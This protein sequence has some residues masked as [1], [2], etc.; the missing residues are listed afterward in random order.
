M[1]LVKDANT[2]SRLKTGPVTAISGSMHAVLLQIGLPPLGFA[3][4][5]GVPEC[6]PAI[7]M[8]GRG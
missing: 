7:F 3:A 6:R 4:A 2:V 5:T 1:K 8:A